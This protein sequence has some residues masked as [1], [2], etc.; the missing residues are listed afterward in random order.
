LKNA[1][2][3]TTA[4][5][6]TKNRKKNKNQKTKKKNDDDDDAEEVGKGDRNPAAKPKCKHCGKIGHS[7]DNCWSL[8]KNAKKRPANY[9]AANAIAKK[10]KVAAATSLASTAELFTEEQLSVMMKKVM[11]SMKEKYGNKRKPKHLVRFEEDSSSSDSD[12][13]NNSDNVSPYSLNYTY[14][15]DYHRNIEA[16]FK[17]GV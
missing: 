7:D 16:P 9:R 5:T 8:E 1:S 13:K 11:S 12:D 3:T 15:F 17:N 10:P 14:L 2:S 6:K 4:K